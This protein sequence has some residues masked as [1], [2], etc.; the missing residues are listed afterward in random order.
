MSKK[1]A[2]FEIAI[3]LILVSFFSLLI[4]GKS[5]S[6]FFVQD[7]F[8]L[9]SISQAETLGGFFRLFLPHPDTA[10]YRPLSQQLFFWLGYRIFGLNP[11]PFHVILFIIHWFNCLL[12]FI[13]L[14]RFSSSFFT[15]FVGVFFYALNISHFLSLSWPAAFGFLL[16][17][18]G[19][20]T[21]IIVFLKFIKSLQFGFSKKSVKYLVASFLIFVVSLFIIEVNIL[22]LPIFIGLWLINDRKKL[23]GKRLTMLLLTLLPFILFA[24][25]ILLLRF[26]IFPAKVGGAYQFTISHFFS[27]LR[28]YFF[29]L[30]G[31]AQSIRLVDLSFSAPHII[32]VAIFGF[33]GF[34]VPLTTRF[35]K[36][37]SKQAFQ[38][39]IVI[40]SFSLLPFLLLPFH[41][42]PHYLNFSLAGVSLMLV[43]AINQF[44]SLLNRKQMI[45]YLTVLTVSI[46][47]AAAIGERM[48]WRTHWLV[49]RAELAK[50]LVKKGIYTAPVASE[51][52]FALGAGGAETLFVK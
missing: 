20:L 41:L 46:I 33:L 34:L 48:E 19:F 18:V 24:M 2:I 6:L 39:G 36:I 3:I 10:W 35:K 15:N 45:I 21:T 8:Y 31:L 25:F 27:T 11:L 22:L 17:P 5:L 14:R 26:F 32:S 4:Y 37:I 1:R 9:L 42:S 13:L 12:V 52:Y 43:V 7:D 28:F 40:A 51:E 16:G 23:L 29:R 47:V 49:R 44:G 50:S 38:T 30:L